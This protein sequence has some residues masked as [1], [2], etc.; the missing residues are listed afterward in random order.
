MPVVLDPQRY[1]QWLDPANR[2]TAALLPLLRPAP[3]GD[4]TLEPVSRQ[5]NDARQ[6]DPGLIE[7]LGDLFRGAPSP[8]TQ[9]H[10]ARSD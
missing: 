1:H 2:D 8:S 3:A 4:W 9:D 7:P 10:R 6:D 5:V